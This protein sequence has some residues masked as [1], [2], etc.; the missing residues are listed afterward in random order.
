MRKRLIYP[1]VTPMQELIEELKKISTAVSKENNLDMVAAFN[2]AIDVARLSIEKEK[3]Q[4][5]NFHVMLMKNGLEREG[6]QI[7]WNYNEL[8]QEAEKY[9]N[10]TYQNK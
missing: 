9:Y 1:R 8:K 7:Y 5:I 4:I 6:N 10:E 2:Y 3:E